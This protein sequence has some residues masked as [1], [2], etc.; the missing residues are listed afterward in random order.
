MTALATAANAES[1]ITEDEFVADRLAF[2]GSFTS[3]V[4]MGAVAIGVL[5]ILMAVFLV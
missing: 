4:T 1:P 2:W 3:F 5:L